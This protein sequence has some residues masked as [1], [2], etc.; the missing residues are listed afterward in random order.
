MSPTLKVR[1]NGR[2]YTV[3]VRDLDSDPVE[4]LVDG[5]PVQ[6]AVDRSG[7]LAALRDPSAKAPALPPR[8]SNPPLPAPG[9]GVHGPG[10]SRPPDPAAPPAGSPSGGRVFEAPMPGVILAV[11]VK[12]GDTIV[13]GDE[14]CMLEAM[15]MQQTLRAEWSGVVR[16]VFVQV[17][18]QIAGGDPIVE[19]E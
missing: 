19:L 11:K 10:V 12:V 13:T 5:E 4:T 6:V 15:K 18:Q 8:R 1:V 9:Q 16:T 3:D 14:V 17:G 2:W 7:E